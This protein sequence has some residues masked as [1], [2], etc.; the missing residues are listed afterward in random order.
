[1]RSVVN[2]FAT[3][4]ALSLVVA[5]GSASAGEIPGIRPLVPTLQERDL[6]LTFSNDFLGRG[7]SVDDFRTQ[8]IILSGKI[9][10]RWR[11]NLDYSML[12]FSGEPEAGRLD[13]ISLSVGYEL[14]NS[15]S[16]TRVDSIT[17]GTGL[18][19]VGQFAG[20]RIQNGFHRI[21]GSDIEALPYT[22]SSDNDLTA[23]IDVGRYRAVRSPADVGF[24]GAWQKGYWLQASTL[25]TTAGQWD[26]SAAVLG[27]LSKPGNDIWLGI[28]S[29]WRTGYD[30]TVLRETA[31]A[32][33]DIAIVLGVRFGPLILETTQ[34]L[35]NDASYGQLRL[36]S[37]AESRHRRR[38]DAKR[39]RG[40][41]TF[42]IL[43]PDV[44]MRLA[45]RIPVRMLTSETSRWHGSVVVGLEYGEPQ[46]KTDTS[47][48]V[49]S[50]QVD[51][52]IEFE[53]PLSG[54]DWLSA[55]CAAGLG[56]RDEKLLS[57][58]EAGSETSTAVGRAALTVGAGFRFD[59]AGS[60]QDWRLRIQLGLVGRRPLSDA[61]V[62]LNGRSLTI[63]RSALDLE[64]GVAVDF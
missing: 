15:R 5:V 16:D 51:A 45:G 52:G 26:S 20:E 29:D 24:M 19:S 50:R 40:G 46:Y 61:N 57:T 3:S 42:G 7:G 48:F 22:G 47:L 17:V 44:Q 41:F 34:Q 30:D 38:T 58:G 60:T 39:V 56:W 2:S 8:Q 54:D 43:M 37:S 59:A 28:R 63:Q 21:I 55:Y 14:V 10:S 6:E 18:R 4:I 62:D 32:E 64:L 23:W 9:A 33:K 36:V 1:M 31:R 12:T 53:R 13:Q 25:T 27:V 11:A 35:D 49:R